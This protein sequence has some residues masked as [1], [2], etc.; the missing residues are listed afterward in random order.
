MKGC[1]LQL[2]FQI[3]DLADVGKRWH[4]RTCIH[5]LIKNTPLTIKQVYFI[6]F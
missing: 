4:I 3:N 2:L 6:E 1:N 5:W